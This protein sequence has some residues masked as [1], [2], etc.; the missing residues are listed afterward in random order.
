MKKQLPDAPAGMTADVI[1]DVMMMLPSDAC[2]ERLSIHVNKPGSQIDLMLTISRDG[3]V[4][5]WYSLSV[6]QAKYVHRHLG[7]IITLK[8]TILAG[9]GRA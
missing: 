3:N 7:N 1:E 5:G 6:E 2:G 4:L 8:E 9:G